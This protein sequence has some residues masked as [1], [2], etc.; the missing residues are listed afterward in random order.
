MYYQVLRR[1]GFTKHE[2]DMVARTVRQ[3]LRTL[4]TCA[5]STGEHKKNIITN[6][7]HKEFKAK[8]MTFHLFV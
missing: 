8:S 4:Y 3:L 5:R 1:K 2:C 6:N 7:M